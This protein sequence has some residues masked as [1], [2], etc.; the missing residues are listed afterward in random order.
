MAKPPPLLESGKIQESKIDR[1]LYLVDE[2]RYQKDKRGV[3]LQ[4][5]DFDG[6][7]RIGRRGTQERQ[8]LTSVLPF[9]PGR[10]A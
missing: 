1:L 4:E 9:G 8:D 7:V 2:R 6:L 10:L 5:P 3:G